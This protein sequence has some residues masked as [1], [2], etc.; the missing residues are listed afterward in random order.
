MSKRKRNNIISLI[1]NTIIFASTLIIVVHGFIYGAGEGQLGEGMK[2]LGYFKA[3]TIDSNILS[4]ICSLMIIIYNIRNIKD[5]SKTNKNIEVLQMVGASSVML[6]F[7]TVL[8]FL[9]PTE[10]VN[11]RDFF[12]M[13]Y[14]D[15]L[16]FHLLNPILAFISITLFNKDN[17]LDNKT[18]F[19]G[20]IPTFLYSILYLVMVVVISRWDDFYGF[21]F[22]GKNYFIP[23]VFVIMYMSSYIISLIITKLHNRNI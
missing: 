20:V 14:G 22:G 16:F 11:G 18:A 1:I 19:L 9:A 4:G 2:G 10:A 21:T 23:A 13:Y 5:N 7:L 17:K 8:L 12:K 15:M 3:F 6:T